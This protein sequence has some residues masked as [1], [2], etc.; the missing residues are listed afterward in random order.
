MLNYLRLL[1][2]QI[3][4]EVGMDFKKNILSLSIFVNIIFITFLIVKLL[5][6]FSGDNLENNIKGSYW[7]DKVSQYEVL[8]SI[9]GEKIFFVGDSM[10]DRYNVE[11]FFPRKNIFNRGNAWDDTY[12]LLSRIDNT[13]LNGNPKKIILFIGGNDILYGVDKS[14][15][16]NNLKELCERIISK[17]V[18][19]IVISILPVWKENKRE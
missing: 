15:F 1:L 2:N 6:H 5:N 18:E 13:V 10:V 7:Q 19:L 14:I 16:L 12:T 11:E 4:G 17:K 8:N 3:A 9:G